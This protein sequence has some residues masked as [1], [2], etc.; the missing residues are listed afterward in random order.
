MVQQRH[1]KAPVAVVGAGP[2]GLATAVLL[3][4]QGLPVTVYEAQARIGGRTRRL[5]AESTAGTFHFDMGPTFFLMPHVLREIFAAAGRDL[6]DYVSLQRLDPM[7]RLVVGQPDGPDVTLDAT[8]D[9]A[10]MRQRVA[11]IHPPDGEA[12]GRFIADNRAKLHAAEPILRRPIRS[13]LDLL[14]LDALRALPHIHPTRSVQDL[15]DQYF[16][17]PAVQL[18]VGFQ[19]KYLGMSPYDC[20][21]LFTILPFIEYEYGIWHPVGGCNALMTAL[22]QL[23]EELGGTI[24]TDTPV[25]ALTFAGQQVTGVRLGGRGGGRSVAHD[26]VIIN[27]D[28]TW[29]LKKFFPAQMRGRHTDRQ[30]DERKY[31]CST[32]MLYLGIEGEVD[33]PHHT[34]RMS[35]HY[36]QNLQDISRDGGRGGTLTQDPSFYV[37]N[38]SPRDATLAPPGHS[39]LYLLLPTP[40]AQADIDWTAQAPRVR[41]HLLQRIHAVLGVD[42]APRIRAEIEV[43]PDQWRDMNINHGATFNLAHGLGQM[44]HRRPQHRV[45]YAR[46]AWMVGGGTHPGSGLPVIF[47]SAQIT[48]N[49]LM[50]QLGMDPA[51]APASPLSRGGAGPFATPDAREPLAAA[52]T[53]ESHAATPS[54]AAA[55]AK[56]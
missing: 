8:Q 28:A 39:S 42:L 12:F 40:N 26:Q 25:E 34:I 22:A 51:I 23:L 30:I 18:A 14:R 13:P 3:A 32:Y 11:A 46:G 17:H 50:K 9:L 47:L 4:A 36:Q 53:F 38:P 48:A 27:A 45:P 2:G 41:E 33:L 20:P 6:A 29:A 43:R 44:L 55:A 16:D 1:L 15:N 37:H 21:S 52:S 49:L 35:P 56:L 19:S 10:E 7:Y 54:P 24:E 31:S 5:S